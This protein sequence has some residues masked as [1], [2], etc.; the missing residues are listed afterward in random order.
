MV[1]IAFDV[2]CKANTHVRSEILSKLTKFQNAPAYLSAEILQITPDF[3]TKCQMRNTAFP[4]REQSI[5]HDWAY[6]K[7]G[8]DGRTP[9]R[10]AAMDTFRWS[11]G[12]MSYEN[13]IDWC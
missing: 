13:I 1:H 6:H 8:I 12:G 10:T 2:C 9:P 4:F 5:K 3:N 7:I 11:A